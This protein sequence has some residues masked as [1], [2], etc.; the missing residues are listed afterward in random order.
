M[1]STTE[2]PDAVLPESTDAVP[3]LEIRNVTAGY[4]RTVVL[5]DVDI[6]VP[7]GTI[8]ALLGPNGAGK[9]TTLRTA[10]GLLSP[11]SGRILLDGAD[12]TSHPSD[13][14]ARAGLCSIPEGR[15][16]FRSLTVRENLRMQL[17]RGADPA[18]VDLAIEAFPVLGQ[19][20]GQLAGSMSGGEQQMLALSRTYLS[21]PSVVL[22]DEVSM[23]LAPKAVDIIFEAI[24]RL[25]EGGVALLLVEQYVTRA[26]EMAD[27][28]VL[29]GRGSVRFS[30]SASELEGDAL[31]RSYLG[32]GRLDAE[33]PRGE[34]AGLVH[35]S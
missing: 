18:L 3:I 23:G 35:E 27:L 34:P 13:R 9:S 7:R 30:G 15:G 31:L 25:A 14:R 6:V 28:V 24:Q 22:L 5:R 4:G 29:L 17:P 16:V 1:S 10:S 26:L 8:V 19:R 33:A 12:V 20:L 2:K 21:Q 11:T 32:A